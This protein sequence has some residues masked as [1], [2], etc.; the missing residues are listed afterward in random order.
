MKKKKDPGGKLVETGIPFSTDEI[1]MIAI[2][3]DNRKKQVIH[4][5]HLSWQVCKAACQYVYIIMS[6]SYTGRRSASYLDKYLRKL[7]CHSCGNHPCTC[8]GMK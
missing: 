1:R 6:G 5:L 8:R 3:R 7:K 2:M 4:R